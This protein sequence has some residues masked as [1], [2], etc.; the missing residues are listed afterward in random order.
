MTRERL[1]ITVEEFNALIAARDALEALRVEHDE[2][3]GELRV[4]KVERDLAK[5]Q[6]QVML[7][8]LFGAKSEKRDPRQEDLFLNEAEMLAPT[9]ATLPALED[10]P[11]T[12][13]AAHK[14][15]KR[16]RK[17]LDPALP[18]VV[19]R[20]ETPEAERFCAQDG[21]ELFEI[22]VEVSEQL[23]IIPQKIQVIR[24]ERVKYACRKCDHG[25]K[26]APA[27]L[28]II[29]RGLFT[30]AA[31]AWIVLS[32]FM[33]G[34]PLY[35]IAA[36]LRRFGGNISRNTLA[37][38][39]IRLGQ[40]IQPVINLMRDVLLDD[41]VAQGDETNVQVLKES[42]KAAQTKSAMWVQMNVVGPPVRLFS[43]ASGHDAK[44]GVAL[45]AGMRKHAALMSDGGDVYDIIAKANDLVHLGCWSHCRRYFFEAEAL[46]PKE[47][48]GPHQP[49]TQFLLLIGRLYAAEARAKEAE[50]TPQ[51]RTV[52]RR[53]YSSKVL[54]RIH[55]LL[56]QYLET[57][58]PSGKLGQALGYLSGQ[59]PKLCRY[60][61]NGLWP[62][63][64]NA[65]ENSIRPYVIG[66]KN[67]LFSDTVA[68]AK[69]SAN[70]YSLVETCR[71]NNVDIYQYL[72]DLFKALP[73][74][75]SADDYEALL[76]W[77]L[78]KPAP[79]TD[80]TA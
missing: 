32:K 28:R 36:L 19:V 30:E 24:H 10:G 34:L 78:G 48:R 47:S 42:G 1:S 45:W 41:E 11:D 15:K 21:T 29:P 60:V 27:P 20:Y 76:P 44:Y 33:D 38:S 77:K 68:G 39:V 37:A 65:C 79:G 31:L 66:R 73:Y 72:I 13:V 4:A 40:S 12:E 6:L 3:R 46:L 54:N 74:A 75:N 52:L 9:A 67:W 8:R 80:V 50:M 7:R 62:I 57:T 56:D 49:A 2:L 25:L 71:A 43:Y 64:N 55:T 35:R 59:W 5:E 23:D 53:R 22:G 17:P 63:C 51:R 69:A 70:L 26:V 61:E 14:R 16:G 18:R 58:L